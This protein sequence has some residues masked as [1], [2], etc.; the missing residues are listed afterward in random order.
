MV[1]QVD[2]D[3]WKREKKHI[4]IRTKQKS[5]TKTQLQADTTYII[6]KAKHKGGRKQAIV[7]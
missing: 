6:L 2:G 3:G 4:K 7:F 1:V 5:R